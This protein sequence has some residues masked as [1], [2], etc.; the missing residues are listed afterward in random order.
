MP[1]I[2]WAGQ[3]KPDEKMIRI[4]NSDCFCDALSAQSIKGRVVAVDYALNRTAYTRAGANEE[5]S[6]AAASSTGSS[7]GNQRVGSLAEEDVE[8]GVDEEDVGGGD[9]D[10]DD[11]DDDDEDDDD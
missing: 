1:S 3:M 8:V 4:A 6:A 11:D 7:K 2:Y 10:D 9:D 5:S